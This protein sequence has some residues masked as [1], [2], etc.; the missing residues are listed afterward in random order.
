MFKNLS[1]SAGNAVLAA[2]T[3]ILAA[4]VLRAPADDLIYSLAAVDFYP[5]DTTAGEL[6]R[7]AGVVKRDTSSTWDVITGGDYEDASPDPDYED[8]TAVSHNKN[9]G[10]SPYKWSRLVDYDDRTDEAFGMS[11]VND[12]VYVGGTYL[13]QTDGR[14]RM[15]YFHAR[16]ADGLDWHTV[17]FTGDETQYSSDFKAWYSSGHVRAYNVGWKYGNYFLVVGWSDHSLCGEYADQTSNS[18]AHALAKDVSGCSLY[19]VGYG[20]DGTDPTKYRLWTMKFRADDPTTPVWKRVLADYYV[21]GANYDYEI[22]VS[23]NGSVY[24]TGPTTS[25]GG[26]VLAK[27]EKDGTWKWTE[28]LPNEGSVSHVA[29]GIAIQETSTDTFVWLTGYNTS[30]P[31]ILHTVAVKVRGSSHPATLL[32]RPFIGPGSQDSLGASQGLSIVSDVAAN[33]V[34]VAG[35][36]SGS[37]NDLILIGYY[38]ASG[39]PT[40]LG[41]SYCTRAMVSGSTDVTGSGVMHARGDTTYAAMVGKDRNNQSFNWRIITAKFIPGQPALREGGGQG[42][43]AQLSPAEPVRISCAPSLFSRSTRVSFAGNPATIRQ[44]DV[45][46]SAGLLVK[47]LLNAPTLSSS[48]SCLWDG[49]DNSGAC[50]PSGTYFLCAATD[51]QMLTERLILQR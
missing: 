31:N 23:S 9:L 7:C 22:G 13:G 34:F 33:R 28:A 24:V 47:T 3:I 10:P 6:V 45:Y 32:R 21:P 26:W 36:R 49:T 51:K 16:A 42:T 11:L 12:R 14:H 25:S 19:A 50:L 35:K 44:L 27:Y 18:R 46:S 15:C 37:Y 29:E 39:Q 5:N 30:D 41:Y 4:L 38:V 20:P 17:A 43:A 8:H 1:K 2:I 40:F 48:F